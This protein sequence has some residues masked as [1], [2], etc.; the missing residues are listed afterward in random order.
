MLR[1][2]L[3][4]LAV[5]AVTGAI[6]AIAS[7]HGTAA[8]TLVSTPTIQGQANDPVVGDVLSITNGQWTGSPTSYT[9]RWQRCDAVGDRQNCVPIAGETAQSHTVQ[10]ADVNHTLNAVVTAKNADGSASKDSKAT[11]VVSADK[12]SPV[13]KARPTVSGSPTVGSTLSASNGTWSGANSFS[14]QWQSC[15]ANGN[16]CS[17]IAGATGR[18]YGVRSSDVGHELRVRVKARN[19]FG[20]TS[21]TSDRTAVV[22]TGTPPPPP[23]PTAG[24]TVTVDKVSLPNRLI[25]DKLTFSPNPTRS[26]GPIVARFHVSDT[27]GYSIEGALVYA[28]GLPYSWLRNASEVPTDASGWATITLEPTAAMPLHRGGALVIFV[29]ARKPGDNLLAGVST[30]RLVQEGIG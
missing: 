24:S 10:S 27:R 16:N 6:A 23:P 9:Y 22:G 15:D 2:F 17:D 19:R 4:V 11:G 7:A 18:T 20:S 25:V 26:H 28:L 13:N 3:G 8:P 21:A 5:L 30:R 1:R 12:T 29:R 14:Y